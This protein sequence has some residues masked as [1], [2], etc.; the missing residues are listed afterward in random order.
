MLLRPCVRDPFQYMYILMNSV[1]LRNNV[2]QS[3]Q[4]RGHVLQSMVVAK[5]EPG[6]TSKLASSKKMFFEEQ[7]RGSD[8]SSE[9]IHRK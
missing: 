8:C 6:T 5:T 1:I 7:F 2:L 4:H 3:P 9:G